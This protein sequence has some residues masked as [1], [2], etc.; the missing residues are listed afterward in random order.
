MSDITTQT[1]ANTRSGLNTPS[2]NQIAGDNSEELNQQFLT[3]LVAQLKNQDPLSPNDPTQYVS[4]LA[5][6]STVEGITNMNQQITDVV[7]MIK[8]QLDTSAL[9]YIGKTVDSET[10][11]I[12]LKE[13][14]AKY[15]YYVPEGTENVTI[16]IYDSEGTLVKEQTLD[17]ETGIQEM[18]W[19][20]LDQY[21]IAK[22]D[23]NY[24]ISVK[25][26]D[27]ND[28]KFAIPVAAK[29]K[30]VSAIANGNNSYSLETESG[31]YI[32]IEDV[33]QVY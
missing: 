17:Q 26:L 27:Q 19:D 21:G 32:D 11:K 31:A 23:G 30:I 15:R 4:Q 24:T 20:G 10:N 5:E 3:L 16:S 14:E 18:N 29:S 28:E 6:F 22:D 7:S 25:G 1:I 13:G 8:G 9:G 12:S 2:T 33:L